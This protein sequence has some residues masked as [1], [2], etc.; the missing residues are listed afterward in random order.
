MELEWLPKEHSNEKIIYNPLD[1]PIMK[2]KREMH[3]KKLNRD[4]LQIKIAVLAI[5]I[6]SVI[7]IYL[8]AKVDEM[9]I[10]LMVLMAMIAVM[11][12]VFA[13]VI[14]SLGIYKIKMEEIV[15]LENGILYHRYYGRD[16]IPNPLYISY[17]NIQDISIE[18][19]PNSKKRLIRLSLDDNTPF[20]KEIKAQGAAVILEETVPDIDL[21]YHLLKEQLEKAKQKVESKEIK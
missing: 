20:K 5:A 2:K 16:D 18:T 6:I 13:A 12:G 15:L 21:F 1:D 9:N 8:A 4:L 19:R 11:A 3:L 17:K 7:L 14:Q 10:A